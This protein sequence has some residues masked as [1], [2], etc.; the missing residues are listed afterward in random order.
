MMSYIVDS[1]LQ[2]INCVEFSLRFLKEKHHFYIIQNRRT[3]NN[4]QIKTIINI[5]NLNVTTI[6][7]NI[8][9][10]LAIFK[11]DFD[12]YDV[13]T[14]GDYRSFFQKIFFLKHSNSR[15]YLVK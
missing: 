13:C 4:E 9:G 8:F 12:E 14:I 6:K 7:Y 11:S 15:K 1:P 10:L 2:L 5:F 3:I